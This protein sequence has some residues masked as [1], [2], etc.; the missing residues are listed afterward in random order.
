MSELDPIL[1]DKVRLLGE[2]LG[3][4]IAN[5]AGQPMFNLIEDIRLQAKT[6]RQ[7]QM[8]GKTTEQSQAGSATEILI[9]KLTSLSDQELVP[10]VRGFNQFLNLSNIAEQQH[11]VSWRRGDWLQ[12]SVD[13]LDDVIERLAAKKIQGPKLSQQIAALNIELVLT[14][15]PTEVTRRTLIRKYDQISSLLQKLDDLRQGDPAESLYRDQL[16]CLITEIWRS[17]EIRNERPSAVDE[18]KWGFAV[19]ENSLWQAIPNLLRDVDKK[20]A[21]QNA[22][23]LPLDAAPINFASWM[24]GDRDGNPNVV[25][26]TTAEVL[27]LA[28]WMAA[29]LYLRD[30]EELGARLSMTQASDELLAFVSG[31]V[32]RNT[33]NEPYRVCMHILRKGLEKTRKWAGLKAKQQ[34]NSDMQHDYIDDEGVLLHSDEILQPLILCYRSL[35]ETGMQDI[36]KQELLDTIRRVSC[37][38]I[39]LLGLDVRQESDRHQQVM[40]EIATYYNIEKNN[41]GDYASWSEAEKQQWLLSELENNRPLL[42]H[43]SEHQWQPSAE[44]QEVLNTVA[45]IASPAGKGVANYVISMAGEP[46][47]ILTVALLLKEKGVSHKVNI[48][49][50]FET[51]D[52]LQQ[53]AARMD[54]IYA[55]PWYKEYCQGEQQVMIGYSDSAKDA[56]NLAAAWAQYQAQ[57]QLVDVAAKHDIK[58]TLF[59][60]RGGTVGRGGGPAGEAILA[61]P[62]GSVS[63]GIRVTEQGEMIRFKFGLPDLAQRSLNIY[64]AATLEATLLPPAKPKDQW[65]KLIDEISQVGVASYRKLVRDTPDFVPY[66]RSATP[67]QELGKLALG[68]RPAR[69]KASG[70]I[71]S[72]RAIPWIFAWTQM[73]LMVPAWLGAD[74]ALQQAKQNH[75]SEV[76]EM[77]QGWPFFRTYLDMLEMVLSKTEPEIARYYEDRL[78]VDELKPLGADIRQRLSEVKQH[79]LDIKQQDHLLEHDPMFSHSMSVRN[80]YTDPLHYLQ[81]ELLQRNR[82]L[83]QD[84]ECA[85]DG[86]CR[87]ESEQVELAL[88]ITMAGI[89]AGMRNTG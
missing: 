73:R 27:Y 53:S 23:A 47:D 8:Q 86:D 83:E 65:L 17:D 14:A 39:S 32:A 67:E 15:H 24:G 72:L 19:I 50:L 70:G 76:Q 63:G 1:R 68:S 58:L 54:Q 49:P 5:D 41:N 44:V 26:K 28:R 11:S 35:S 40:S 78:V 22:P 88:K 21:E 71:E 25:A 75:M 52:D 33:I 2:L 89:A 82:K 43:I 60:G 64:L 30:I 20:L 34:R 80:P 42:P 37:F 48:V 3:E 38:G 36:A 29:D 16:A 45:V 13:V 81:A 79:L 74:D 51:L 85:L 4:T 66:F 57:Q 18:A 55:L 84:S 87:K 77:Y 59:H 12:D 61:Q 6:A 7:E 69:R 31:T 9:N 10:V 46:S 56:G 62:P